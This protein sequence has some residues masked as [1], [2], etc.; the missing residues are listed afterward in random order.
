MFI[1]TGD[2]ESIQEIRRARDISIAVLDVP[3]PLTP[4]K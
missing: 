1:N 3:T 2:L 4:K